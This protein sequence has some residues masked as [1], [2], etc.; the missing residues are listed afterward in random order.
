MSL[1]TRRSI[2]TRLIPWE[3][4]AR[5]QKAEEERRGRKGILVR[6]WSV[7]ICRQDRTRPM[8]APSQT[9]PIWFYGKIGNDTSKLHWLNSCCPPPR[10]R[11]RQGHRCSLCSELSP[12]W[13]RIENNG[14]NWRVPVLSP[15]RKGNESS[16]CIVRMLTR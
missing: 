7:T 14:F 6:E 3:D 16:L 4:K 2:T 1:L 15:P 9:V 8:P 13:P 12:G 5:Q 10:R 11:M